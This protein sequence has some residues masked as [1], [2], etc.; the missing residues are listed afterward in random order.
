[1]K[2]S[3]RSY[4]YFLT[5]TRDHKNARLAELKQ[6]GAK[7]QQQIINKE[8]H[9]RSDSRRCPENVNGKENY[10]FYKYTIRTVPKL[11][12]KPN[13]NYLRTSSQSVNLVIFCHKVRDL[14]F[15]M[16]F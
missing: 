14:S 10:F 15:K 4:P 13:S 8:R 1:M 6:K 3:G 9:P 5:G 16:H 7:L 2:Y 11:H 12:S